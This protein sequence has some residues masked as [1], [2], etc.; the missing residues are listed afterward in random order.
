MSKILHSIEKYYS[1]KFRQHGNNA[2]EVDWKDKESQYIRFNQ[3][4]KILPSQKV[5][6]FSL[7]DLGC[8]YGEM[9]TFLLDQNYHAC[10]YRGYDLSE[11][12]I[13]WAKKAYN[14]ENCTFKL[15]TVTGDMEI[16]D[17]SIAS[18][19]FNVRFDFSNEEWLEHILDTLKIIDQKSRKGFAFNILT[20]YSDAP[21]MQDHLYYAN[22][23][24][25]FQFCKENFSRNVAL[26][27]DYE[28]YEFTIIV[29]K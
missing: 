16:S 6:S 14:H 20:S 13:L 12:M 3:L 23:A 18:G 28:L 21:Y 11:E 1:D 25:F 22:P 19:I 10:T 7:N 24:F 5:S 2:R 27:H 9:L 4:K 29:R 15:I 8:G 17:Y 26:L